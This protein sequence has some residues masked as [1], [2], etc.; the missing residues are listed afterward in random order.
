MGSETF[1]HAFRPLIPGTR[2]LDFNSMDALQHITEHTACV[3][4]ETVQAEAGCITGTIEFLQ[5]LRKRCTKTGTLLI[6]DEVQTGFGRTGKLF[7]FEESGIVPDVIVFAKGMGGGMPIGAFVSSKEHMHK[8]THTPVLGH[9]TT[10]GGHPVSCAAAAATIDIITGEKL[11]EEA[12]RKEE[13]IRTH[14]KHDSIKEIRGK[15][16]MLAV[17]FDNYEQNKKIIDA[18]L[19][20]GVI[21]DWFLFCDHAMR[22]APPLNIEET[23]LVDAC[24]KIVAAIEA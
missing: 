5:A 20:Q 6:L 2:L 17:V 23:D 9:I 12:A 24:R 13:L 3:I 22:I 8:L 16:L 11:W 4:A 15:G 1:K 18:A 7:G 10:F 21:T 14:L 19:A